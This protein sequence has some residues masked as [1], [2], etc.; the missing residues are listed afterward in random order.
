MR[1]HRRPQ[2]SVARR[3]RNRPELEATARRHPVLVEHSL[4]PDQYRKLFDLKP[5]YPMVAPG[6]AQRRRELALQIG[7]GRRKKPARRRRKKPM[8]ES[9]PGEVGQ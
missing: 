7:L 4:T 8:T 5:D 3:Q 2:V 6:Y 9:W 1:F